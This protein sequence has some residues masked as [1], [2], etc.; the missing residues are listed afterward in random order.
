MSTPNVFI[1]ASD[2]SP[3]LLPLLHLKPSLALSQD[4]HGYSLV[5][6]AASYGHH[7]LLR[8]L[9]RDFQVDVNIK[10]EDGE[11]SLFA[12]ET[13]ETAKI[14]VEELDCDT[15][16]KNDEGLTAEEKIRTEGDFV[17]VADYLRTISTRAASE[18]S[19]NDES[20]AQRRQEEGP[21][22]PLPPN[23]TVNM[24]TTTEDEVPEDV[25]PA[26]RARIEDL[27]SREDFQGEE[28]QKQLRDLV[29]DA[30]RKVEGRDVRRRV[31]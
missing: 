27:A 17:T 4:E 29:T 9:I 24:G 22:P 5:H 14:L 30:V 12:V 31:E 15:S 19:P 6:A 7:E 2:N 11:T 21:L 28:G 20:D 13:V 23:V 25:D 18:S 8:T 16:L 3:Q 26:F 1:L 10:D